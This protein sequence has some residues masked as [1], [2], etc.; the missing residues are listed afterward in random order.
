MN[1]KFCEPNHRKAY[2]RFGGLPFD[3]MKEQIMRDVRKMV[4]AEFAAMHAQPPLQTGEDGSALRE[5]VR[6]EIGRYRLTRSDS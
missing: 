4:R 5:I 1:A 6:E 2:W 3:K